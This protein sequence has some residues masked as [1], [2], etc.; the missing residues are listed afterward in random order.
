MIAM[1]NIEARDKK[2]LKKANF[3]YSARRAFVLLTILMLVGSLS[4]L[5]VYKGPLDA[6]GMAE[7]GFI[8]TFFWLFCA[9]SMHLKI[10]HSESI[11][12]Y[13]KEAR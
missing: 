12:H 6:V 1:T 10:R 7:Q 9:Y 4:I 8:G 13:L 5:F 2:M 3:Y 11:R